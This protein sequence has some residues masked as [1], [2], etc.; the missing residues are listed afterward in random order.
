MKYKTKV[1]TA[2][3]T[4]FINSWEL[5]W[6]QSEYANAFNSYNWFLSHKQKSPAFKIFACYKDDKLVGVCPLVEGK[7]FGITC[8]MSPGKAFVGDVPFIVKSYN[9]ELLSSLFGKIRKAGNISITNVEE[10]V[11]KDLKKLFPQTQFSLISV[12]PYLNLAS[13]YK[14]KISKSNIKEI[15]KVI[16]R[17]NKDLVLTAKQGKALD[18]SFETMVNLE[19][20]SSKKSKQKDIFSKEDNT[21]LYKEIVKN[22]RKNVL[23]AFLEYKKAPIA[24]QFGFLVK[25]RFSAYQTAFLTG[26]KDINPG[27]VMLYKLFDHLSDKKIKTFDLGGG[28]SS[29][30]E[31]FTNEYFL[32]YDMNFSNNPIVGLLWKSINCVRRVKQSMF[33]KKNT[34]DHEFL[35]KSL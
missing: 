22:L 25:N 16:K 17:L 7:V 3:N 31:S 5:L 20:H 13:N 32:M 8:L 35:F 4:D 21:K 29:Y 18:K 34:R 6:K 14:A 26:H 28:I 15:N 33:P 12:I 19:Q 23:I 24:Y 2:L 1:L 9:T 27:R 10:S 11:A 30:K